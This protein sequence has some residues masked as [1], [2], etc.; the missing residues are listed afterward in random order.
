MKKKKYKNKFLDGS[1]YINNMQKNQITTI[2]EKYNFLFPRL[3]AFITDMFLLNM[4]ILYITT[5]LLLDGKD[6]FL[7]NQFAISLCET[8]YC[9]ILFLFFVTKGQ[10]P[11]FRYAEIMLCSNVDI[12]NQQ[13]PPK[14]MQTLIFILVWLIELSFFLWIFLFIRKDKKTLHELISNTKIVYKANPAKQ[15][16]EEGKKLYDKYKDNK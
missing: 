11:G 12:N 3:K 13:R 8:L 6:D 10:T 9:F 1:K 16:Y 2:N 5:Y 15:K 14:A 4:P 7:H